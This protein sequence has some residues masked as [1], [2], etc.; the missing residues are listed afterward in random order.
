MRSTPPTAPASAEGPPRSAGHPPPQRGGACTRRPDPCRLAALASLLLALALTPLNASAEGTWLW[1]VDAPGETARDHEQLLSDILSRDPDTTHLVGR[2]AI[3]SRLRAAPPVP[4]CVRGVGSCPHPEN[5]L[6]RMLGADL[7]VVLHP[8][9]DGRTI[10][11][12]A[13]DAELRSTRELR[14]E[15]ADLRT[16]LLRAVAELTGATAR[17]D[18]VSTPSGA[19]VLLDGERVGT[20][21][22]STTLPVGAYDLELQLDGHHPRT[23]R[24]ELRAGDATQHRVPLERR[25]ADLVV[26]SATEGAQ[27]TLQ[28][29]DRTLTVAPGEPVE[30][31]PGTWTIETSAP[32]YTPRRQEIQVAAGDDRELRMNLLL[33]PATILARRRDRILAR[34]TK[35]QIGANTAL[36]RDDASALAGSF[37]GG[38]QTIR[39]TIG[40]EGQCDPR[41]LGHLGLHLD[42]LHTWN[43]FEL[44]II[45]FGADLVPASETPASLRGGR[46]DVLVESGTR[47]EWRFLQP[48]VRYLL[49]AVVE[50]HAR[51]GPA[52][53]R[54]GFD[55]A[56]PLGTESDTR[57]HRTR[58]HAQLHAGVRL[59]LNPL[60]Y[61]FTDL[62]WSAPL[63]SSGPGSRF[64]AAAGI[65]ISLPDPLGINDA[66]DR[67]FFEE[68]RPA[69]PPAAPTVLDEETP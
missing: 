60:A 38:D 69:P 57:F 51:L 7:L 53:V 44:Q 2:G 23:R 28:S 19:T 17:V 52:I 10:R 1:L 39:C 68:S 6:L 55:I 49:N 11:L 16:A 66:L 58:L 37:L 46:G 65:G 21:P 31:E 5:A 33:S 4:P 12:R 61:V 8:H 9:D 35:I 13:S 30:L 14:V 54:E 64:G 27:V 56:D 3:E 47:T 50:P 24:I 36:V 22:W 15:G 26:R 34:P 67:A 42:V 45:G 41:T 59:H 18:V 20:T 40:D 32:G 63:A 62:Q 29:D 25:F 48:G 43:I